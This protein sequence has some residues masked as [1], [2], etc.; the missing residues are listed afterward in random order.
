VGK[1]AEANIIDP[2]KA[3]HIFKLIYDETPRGGLSDD[4]LESMTGYRQ[5]EIRKILRMLESYG[6]ATHKRR[7]HPEK[8]V[9]RYFWRVDPDT[10]NVVLLTKKKQVLKRL[11]ERLEYEESNRFYVCPED[12]NRLTEEEALIHDYQCPRC[13]APLMEEDR[14]EGIE[15][16]REKIRILE[17]E[18]ARDEKRIYS[19]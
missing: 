18:I 7:R 5:G 4:D 11:K 8:D 1:L 13:G 12:G 15:K 2:R 3:I 6:L 17:E 9:S 16:L 19:G 10:I 14:S